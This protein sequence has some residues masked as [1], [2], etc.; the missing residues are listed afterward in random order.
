MPNWERVNKP[1]AGTKSARHQSAP[2]PPSRV[3]GDS[4]SRVLPLDA[5]QPESTPRDSRDPCLPSARLGLAVALRD[6]LKQV[7]RCRWRL[8]PASSE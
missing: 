2:I 4:D 6:R 3:F 1:V 7:G 8:A 5:T